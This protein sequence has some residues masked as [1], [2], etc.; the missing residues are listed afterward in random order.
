MARLIIA[1]ACAPSRLINCRLRWAEINLHKEIAGWISIFTRGRQ[2]VSALFVASFA[3]NWLF[4]R[5]DR[6][7][8]EFN[9]LIQLPI[10]LALTYKN[11]KR[12]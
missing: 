7:Q 11:N 1:M 12:L 4:H 6:I 9:F 10:P 3:R 8:K 2:S 5:D